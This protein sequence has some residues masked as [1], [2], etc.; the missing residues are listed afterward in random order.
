VVPE[1]SFPLDLPPVDAGI[2]AGVVPEDSFPLDLPPVDAGID[3]GGVVADDIRVLVGYDVGSGFASH[4]LYAFTFAMS[5][6]ACPIL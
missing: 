6:H 1:D 4:L 2:D 5:Q 3:A